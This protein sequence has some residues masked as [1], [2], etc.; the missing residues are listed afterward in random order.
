[1]AKDSFGTEAI[2]SRSRR[3]LMGAG[4]T[5]GAAILATRIAGAPPM[6]RGSKQI[7]PFASAQIRE[8]QTLLARRGHDVGK[9]DGFLGLKSRA[10][11]KAEQIKLGLPADS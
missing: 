10:A 11:V 4:V 2:E 1:M 8:L 3:N 7:V 9:I 5:I 6:H